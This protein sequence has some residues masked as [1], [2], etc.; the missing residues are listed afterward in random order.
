MFQRPNENILRSK[1]NVAGLA[2]I[3]LTYAATGSGFLLSI[4]SFSS[5]N[6]EEPGLGR[7]Q[8]R[9]KAGRTAPPSYQ[10][11]TRIPPRTERA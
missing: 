6:L 5:E 4:F 7:K 2:A 10:K 3:F 9:R 1:D 8:R 11:R